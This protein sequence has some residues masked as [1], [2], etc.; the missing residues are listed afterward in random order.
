[1]KLTLSLGIG[2]FLIAAIAAHAGG[3]PVHEPTTLPQLAGRF[4][5]VIEA[6]REKQI[7]F[8]HVCD[9]ANF[10]D[11]APITE[12]SKFKIFSVSKSFTGTLIMTLVERGLIALDAPARQYV[13]EMPVEWQ[14]I[15]RL[16]AP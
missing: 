13:P 8:R 14:Q 12:A 7:V 16:H 10:A 4:W 11:G 2:S 6:R 5:G 1:M 3:D 15:L 9:F